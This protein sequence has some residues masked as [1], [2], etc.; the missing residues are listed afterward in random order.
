MSIKKLFEKNR[1]TTVVSKYL[2]NTNISTAGAGLESAGHLSES[3]KKRDT[4]IPPIDYSKPGNFAK[5]GSAEKY[6][7]DAFQY[8]SD[9]YPYDGSAFEKVK[10]ENDL[11]L[12]EKYIFNNEYPK[13][14]GHEGN[15]NA[16]I[17]S[18]QKSSDI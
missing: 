3:L 12:F 14:L 15:R 4:F 11:N 13:S 9:Y 18:I 16:S 2:K 10:F 5:F 6:Y 8:I 7:T 1:Q 17:W